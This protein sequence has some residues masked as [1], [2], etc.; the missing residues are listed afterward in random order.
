MSFDVLI[1]G[2]LKGGVTVRSSKSGNPFATFKRRY[3]EVTNENFRRSIWK[4]WRFYDPPKK[5]PPSAGRR[6]SGLP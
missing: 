6:Y 3:S 1:Q 4:E 2:K 5:K